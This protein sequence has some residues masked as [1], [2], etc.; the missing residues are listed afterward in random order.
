[1]RWGAVSTLCAALV[2]EAAHGVDVARVWHANAD[3]LRQNAHVRAEPVGAPALSEVTVLVEVPDGTVF[4]NL[5]WSVAGWA[6]RTCETPRPVPRPCTT[7]ET[8]APTLPDPAFYARD[9]WPAQ[10][11]EA[12]GVCCVAGARTLRVRV[13]PE[14]W[15]GAAW[16][17]ARTGTVEVARGLSF[18]A[19]F[20]PAP[21]LRTPRRAAARAAAGHGLVIVAPPDLR[22][23]WDDYAD[24]RRRARPDWTVRV[25]GTDEIYRDYPFGAAQP[26][27]NAAES[28]HAFLRDAAA[29]GTDH[30]LLGG[31]WLDAQRPDDAVFFETGE[32]LSLSNCV[33]GVRARPYVDEQCDAVPSDLFFACLD[34]V[35]N[36]IAHPWDPNGNGVYL[37]EAE[38]AGCDLAADL[39]VGRV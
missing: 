39:A 33:P 8:P 34:D 29:Q 11:V 16:M 36:G 27:R 19:H 10:P 5:S 37:D 6:A 13:S 23:A 26:C 17:Q 1:M 31:A 12:C 4:S 35:A 21:A 15:R 32:R 20:S 38:W 14:R 18:T 30:V 25:V 3:A 7:D 9:V 2:V 28:I 24:A 22:T